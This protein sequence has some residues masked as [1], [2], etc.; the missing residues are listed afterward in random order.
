MLSISLDAEEE[1][2]VARFYKHY[3]LSFA[4]RA[5]TATFEAQP[6]NLKTRFTAL[7]LR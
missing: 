2:E 4:V 7:N 1:K 6:R 5:R 3:V